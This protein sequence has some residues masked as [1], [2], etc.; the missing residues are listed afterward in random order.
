[1]SNNGLGGLAS[2]IAGGMLYHQA[3]KVK[4]ESAEEKAARQKELIR[5]R[6]EAKIKVIEAQ[7]KLEEERR[8]RDLNPRV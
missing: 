7:R 1:M 2:L 4:L 8:L 5:F 6:A 3:S